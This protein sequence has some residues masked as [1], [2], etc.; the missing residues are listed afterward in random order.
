MKRVYALL[1]AVLPPLVFPVLTYA[2]ASGDD[3]APVCYGYAIVGYDMV[4]NARLGVP[5]DLAVG[6][7]AKPPG[8]GADRHY[9]IPVLKV[10]L[11]AYAWR[12]GPDEYATQVMDH[13]MRQTSGK[14]FDTG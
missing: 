5:P 14:C 9:S 6:L 1:I 3:G 2:S 7:A 8:D 13:C 11:E 4:V 12:G 10:V